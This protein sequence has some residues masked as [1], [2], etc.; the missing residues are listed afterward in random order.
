MITVKR[1]R[2]ARVAVTG[3]IG[4]LASI[5]HL[6]GCGGS[7]IDTSEG[8]LQPVEGVGQSGGP[9]EAG[10]AVGAPPVPTGQAC[11][12]L[13]DSSPTA[14]WELI[15]R[16]NLE[17]AFTDAGITVDIQNAGGDAGKFVSIASE[18]LDSGCSALVIVSID[19]EAS[20]Q[21]IESANLLGVPVI[22]YD[23]L[24]PGG[25]SNY[26]VAVDSEK[27]GSMMGEG[28]VE[29]MR[30]SGS[31]KGSVALLNGPAKDATAALLEQGYSA[32]V[33]D[34]GFE[35]VA[36]HAVPKW[37]AAEGETIFAQMLAKADGGF[38]GVI[39]ANDALSGSVDAVLQREGKAGS[40]PLVGQGGN[41]EALQRVLLGTQCM[42]VFASY[43]AEATA[44][45][46][47]AADLINGDVPAAD[48]AASA[49]TVDQ[50]TGA[51]V[52]SVLVEPRAVF[53]AD[54]PGLVADGLT[55]ADRLCTS[56]EL[57][58]ACAK[59]GLA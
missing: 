23:R 4:A 11:V 15:D 6:A 34:A 5:I 29:C 57:K 3:A 37:D 20:S 36:S 26:L 30:K 8:G 43:E 17:K 59:A 27:T 22:D 10:I 53:V 32:A 39:A 25:G 19:A 42:T 44:V 2:E 49:V 54:V 51:E 50:E 45:A 41:D 14:R 58:A 13:P 38:S 24:S 46:K 56:A 35:V 52:A 31:E 55:L 48:E 16:P 40:I 28:L 47:L 33:T 21:V 18:M 7:G 9:T 12:V 1:K